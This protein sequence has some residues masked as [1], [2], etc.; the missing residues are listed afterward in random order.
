MSFFSRGSNRGG[1][2]GNRGDRGRRGRI[3]NVLWEPGRHKKIIFSI[4]F[5]VD[6]KEFHLLIRTGHLDNPCC[7]NL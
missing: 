4:H 2:K 6:S 7:P 5:D 3:P 1:N